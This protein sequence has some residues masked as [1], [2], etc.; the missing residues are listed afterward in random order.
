MKND[1][2][3]RELHDNLSAFDIKELIA[4]GSYGKVFRAVHVCTGRQYALKVIRKAKM[5]N[6]FYASKHLC[7]E[8][9]I[10]Q[11]LNHPFIAK[12]YGIIKTK[13]HVVIVEEY[14]S[15]GEFYY[16]IQKHRLT[17]EHIMFFAAEIVIVLEYLQQNGILFRDLK[18]EN[19]ML[20]PRGHIK[21]IDF[22]LATIASGQ[23]IKERVFTKTFCGTAEYL[24]PEILDSHYYGFA[25][26]IWSLGCIIFECLTRHP[27]FYHKNQA[28]M[29]SNIKTSRV[30]IPD[31]CSAELK[32]LI[33]ALLCKDWR[34]RPSLEKIKKHPWFGGIDWNKVS[35][36]ELIPPIIPQ[37]DET[38]KYSAFIREINLARDNSSGDSLGSELS[39]S[40]QSIF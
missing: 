16:H 21:F 20:D 31:Y 38:I 17:E 2:L 29:F 19:I 22:G 5:Q 37:E 33:N 9:Q 40:I 32:D 8:L 15:G 12:C 3:D 7:M 30:P 10:I 27:P 6:P 13:S 1:V 23:K 34:H 26:D 14:I 36:G 39:P 4:V 11:S 28:I 35:S 18:P 25:V 24:A